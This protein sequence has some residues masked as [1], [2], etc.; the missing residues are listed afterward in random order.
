MLLLK[1]DQSKNRPMPAIRRGA[2][3]GV[4][5]ASGTR[6]RDGLKPAGHISGYHRS[7][8][9]ASFDRRTEGDAP[10]ETGTRGGDAPDRG[11]TGSAP[12]CCSVSPRLTHGRGR[13]VLLPCGNY[14]AVL[15][16]GRDAVRSAMGRTGLRRPV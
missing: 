12:D 6:S 16:V 7:R 10:Y 11:M 8:P 1:M 3:P 5:E 13:I 4:A 15:T 9:A 14:P 2:R